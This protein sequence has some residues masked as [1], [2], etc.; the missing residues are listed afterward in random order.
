MQN[1][2]LFDAQEVRENLL[3]MTF[4]RPVAD[5]RVGVLTIREKWERMLE[6]VYSYLTVD[7]LQEKY[8]MV[9]A[10]DN[11]FIAGNVCPTANLVS[12]IK[13]LKDG[14]SLVTPLGD[15]IAY[16]G[17]VEGL[18]ECSFASTVVC[19]EDCIMIKMLYDIF[20]ENHRGIVEDFALLTRGRKSEPLSD[21]NTVI[22]N[23]VDADGNSLIFIEEGAVVEGAMLNVKNGPI[24]V[25]RNAEVME[26]SCLRGPIALCENA[27]INMGARV[28]GATTLGPF[29]KVGGEV[30]NVVMMGYSNK[31]HDGFLGNAVI[32]EWC[33][34]GG[35][36]TASNLKNDYTEIKLWNYLAHRFLRT[37]LQFCGLIMGDHSK[38]GINCMFNTAT[39]LGVGVN[40]H[41]AGF[42]RNFVASFSEGSVSGF[43]DVPLSKF[44]DIARRMMARRGLTLSE[45]D[46]R[47]FESIHAFAENY[48]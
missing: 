16:R 26:G 9:E 32:G 28:Y 46:M 21:T 13:A 34:I 22:G 1:I 20:M 17:G 7:Y 44:F 31:A 4:T 27:V 35:G 5:L 45:I 11:V 8:P 36:S 15:L 33:N 18:N 48:K 19:E 37:G 29:C 30:N 47:I 43:T 3:P 12:K 23:P 25:G 39:V 41:G 2:I 10:A 6:G 24:Y 38:S 14:E 42:P 40:I